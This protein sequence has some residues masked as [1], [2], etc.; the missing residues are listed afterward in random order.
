MSDPI[1]VVLSPT[2]KIEPS[3]WEEAGV[4]LPGYRACHSI[5]LK[6]GGGYLPPPEAWQDRLGSER[7]AIWR[8]LPFGA[9][10]CLGALPL[11]GLMFSEAALAAM[12]AHLFSLAF[13]G[14]FSGQLP[15]N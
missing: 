3:S 11:G 10:L 13:I 8:T 1:G 7:S 4:G 9:G 14:A 6:D 5:K 12:Y 2:D 15:I